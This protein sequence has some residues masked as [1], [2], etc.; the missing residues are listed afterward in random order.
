MIAD[1]ATSRVCI[2]A[3]PHELVQPFQSGQ[4]RRGCKATS[5]VR[6]PAVSY[7]TLLVLQLEIATP[8]SSM[9]LLHQPPRPVGCRPSWPDWKGISSILPDSP[10]VPFSAASVSCAPFCSQYAGDDRLPACRA[11]QNQSGT[12]PRRRHFS[13]FSWLT[14]RLVDPTSEVYRG[15]EPA[16]KSPRP[17]GALLYIVVGFPTRA[18]QLTASG[19][20][21][22]LCIAALEPAAALHAEHQNTTVN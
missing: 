19:S 14:P 20:P 22:V 11:H 6:C 16:W 5:W 10:N 13:G 9:H 21:G 3:S 1:H 15:G 18:C 17:A 2:G 7:P 8:F 4:T 12:M